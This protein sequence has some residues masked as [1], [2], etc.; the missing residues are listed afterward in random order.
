MGIF[1]GIK[2]SIVGIANLIIINP[3]IT[4]YDPPIYCLIKA[5]SDGYINQSYCLVILARIVLF[6]LMIKCPIYYKNKIE[7]TCTKK[8]LWIYFLVT[9]ILSGYHIID[10]SLQQYV[11]TFCNIAQIVYVDKSSSDFI[12]FVI[13][14]VMIFPVQFLVILSVKKMKIETMKKG[15]L[16]V[17]WYTN[18]TFLLTWGVPNFLICLCYLLDARRDIS[19]CLQDLN[20]LTICISASME[21]P[22]NYFKN[23]EFKKYARKYIKKDIRKSTIGR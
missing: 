19:F 17:I 12:Q 22:F 23:K 13:I 18:C 21:L 2:N 20:V 11:F 3:N 5:I 16:S 15:I 4:I 14:L 1:I 8:A 9:A 10:I 6:I 7:R